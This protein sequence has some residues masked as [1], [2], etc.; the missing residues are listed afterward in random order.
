M[1]LSAS[2]NAW[3]STTS[4]TKKLVLLALADEADDWGYC[5]PS[6]PYIAR[7]CNVSERTVYRAIDDLIAN[8]DVRQI[9]SGG[10]RNMQGKGYSNVYQVITTLSPQQ[11]KLSEQASP[12]AREV[13][14][15]QSTNTPRSNPDTGDRVNPDNLSGLVESSDN[16]VNN[17]PT[18]NPDTDDRVNPDTGDRVN[19]DNLSGL[20][21]SSDNFV[22]NTPT[23]NPDTDDR[24]NPDTGDRVNPDNL[25][26]NPIAAVLTQETQRGNLNPQVAYW[27]TAAIGSPDTGVRV[28]PDNLSGLLEA[29]QKA[30]ALGWRGKMD[31][32]VQAYLDDPERVE[33]LLWYAH[34]KKW[35]GGLLRQAINSGEY[36]PDKKP[37]GLDPHSY[38]SGK[39][40]ELFDNYDD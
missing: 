29:A 2:T 37:A 25:S 27:L 32:F 31:D 35:G 28:N 1:S 3:K 10:G 12:L 4:G 5:Y 22:N 19:P 11:I 9:R 33:N 23:P 21:E 24:V 40:A 6:I 16:F 26:P 20:V 36:P 38:L 17:T 30:F 14:Q 15:G 39:Y 18:P 13:L 8:G 7:R 34:Q